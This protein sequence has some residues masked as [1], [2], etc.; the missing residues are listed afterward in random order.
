MPPYDPKSVEPKQQAKWAT[1]DLYAAKDADSREKL[2]CLVEFPYP[3]GNL[4]VG[5]WYAFA[6]PDMYA[7]FQRMSGKNVMFPI[8]FDAFGLPAENAAIK[9]GLNPRDWTRQN[10]AKMEEQLRSMGASFDWSRQVKTCEPEYYR[11]TQWIFL[12]LL[13]AGLAYQAEVAVNWCPND[14]T[15]LANEQVKDGKCDRCG[16]EVEQRKMRQWMLRTTA[17]ADALVDDLEGLAWPEA[18]KAAQREWIGRSEGAEFDF[19]I[20]GVEEAVT[21]FTTRADT[22]YGV[23]YVV[24]APEHPL[25]AK[26]SAACPNRAAVDA[27]VAETAKKR[28]LD[29]LAGAGDKTGVP[30][31]G[32]FATNPAN[33]ERVPV[34]VAD[35]VL[36][37]YGTGAVM[38]VPA[39]DE[40]DWEFA[41]KYSL[42]VRHVV[43]PQLVDRANPHV[44]G[45]P[46]VPR[47]NIIA[48]IR[49]AKTG[50]YLCLKW[51]EQP[52]TTFVIG[53]VEDGEDPVEAAKREIAEEAG[54]P[55]AR[56]VRVLGAPL[57][58][59]YN[60]AHKKQ[61]RRSTTIPILFE[62]DSEP[63][64]IGAE[65]L[66]IHEPFWMDESE[67]RCGVITHTETDILMHRV[68]TGD[69][70]WYGEGFLVSSGE[71]DGQDWAGARRGIAQKFGRPKTQYRLRDWLVSR[72]R[73]WGCPIP[74]VHC[75]KCGP[76]GVPESE[77]PV[78]LPAIDSYLPA[79]DG[80]S[81]LA[82]SADFVNAK[83]P[84]CG[85]AARRETDTLDTFIDSSWYFYRY[86]DPKNA[87]AFASPE[88]LAQWLPVDVYAGG[89]E[90]TTMH[91]FFARFVAK[92]LHSLGLAPGKE[93]F[94]Y[95][96]NRSLILGPD[97]QKMSKSK[98][99]VIDPDAEVARYG[100]DTV[101]MYLAFMGPYAEVNAYPWDP[102]GIT[103]VR[104]FLDRTWRLCLGK[105]MEA[106]S[107]AARRAIHRA[108]Q[109]VGEDVARF[110]LNTAIAAL[111]T[112][113]TEL[114]KGGASAE[115]LRLFLRLV[116]PFAP[117]LAD[118]LWERL[119][120][121]GTVHAQA[122][123][124]AD[125]AALAETSA[126]IAVQVDG[127]VRATLEMARGAGE[128]DVRAAALA[129]PNVAKWLSGRNVV[130]VVLVPD[131]L[132]SMVTE[133]SP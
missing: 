82:R 43:R 14:K 116:A 52:W 3:S 66:A 57:Q 126:K 47:T 32:V 45:Q 35:Y 31:E 13:D 4:H 107:E 84:K 22:L 74:V 90:H 69:D 19:K 111:M 16:A 59:D 102:N 75:E 42:P 46:L 67:L 115:D 65:E 98:G 58:T 120:G 24:L 6:V 17:F 80:A 87:E 91:V 101:R 27:Y 34:W 49:H 94:A 108:I 2:Y 63:T 93:P 18:I 89:A 71:F 30:L 21:V 9:H 124:E 97:G 112:C 88:K 10:M 7:R 123:P 44:E 119:G 121:E 38:A 106:T 54:I 104:R 39:H 113:L 37:S 79:D 48:L 100:A 81:P 20:D 28:E 118:E 110:K 117:H 64:G 5:H 96:F 109:K 130:K 125:P 78:E 68:R 105:Q 70:G 33:G 83:C 132:L 128:D 11:W 103:G 114:E 15:V 95:R 73:Y 36:G 133:P 61:N 60:A 122:W 8:G 76:V 26:L 40:R 29:R 92:A 25:V 131:R 56:L 127:K 23:T 86:A 41:K 55:D 62:T 50:K 129:E 85:G 1:A 77:L 99:N 72:Q 51:K 53:G 12:K